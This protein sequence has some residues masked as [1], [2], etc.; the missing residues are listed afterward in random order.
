MEPDIRVLASGGNAC[1]LIVQG[2]RK[3]TTVRISQQTDTTE[4]EVKMQAKLWKRFA[5]YVVELIEARIDDHIPEKY[6]RIMKQHDACNDLIELWI[7]MG[8]E[9]YSIIETA[10]ARLGSLTKYPQ[11]EDPEVIRKVCFDVMCFLYLAEAEYGFT[12]NDLTANNIV[13][14][15]MGTDKTLIAQIID[16]DYARFN[17]QSMVG[18]AS[19]TLGSTYVL[20][21]EVLDMP[22]RASYLGAIDL[23]SLGI[24][25]LGCLMG[26]TYFLYDEDVRIISRRIDCLQVYLGN[27]GD[28]PPASEHAYMKQFQQKIERMEET[29]LAFYRILLNPDPLV[30]IQRGE[31]YKLLKSSPYF[32]AIPRRQ[33]M[34][35]A[36]VTD[37]LS[38]MKFV[39]TLKTTKKQ[40]ER[41]ITDGFVVRESLKC[42]HC[43]TKDAVYLCAQYGFVACSSQC[44]IAHIAK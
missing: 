22:G 11:K 36:L 6:L 37:R 34:L 25:M 19:G 16:Y 33:E 5:P 41:A 30:R 20:P 7:R 28:I 31:F 3:K 27:S 15:T 44:K 35:K 13:L 38:S 39:N 26:H 32:D 10:Y 24:T 14:S 4:D 18:T 2:K 12:H 42:A 9:T 8:V 40:L 43:K 23:W 1:V 21:P 29:T 17:D